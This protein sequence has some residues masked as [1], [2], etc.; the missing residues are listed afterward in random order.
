ML[1]FTMS[2]STAAMSVFG[3]S[4]DLLSGPVVVGGPSITADA[5]GVVRTPDATPG[6][7]LLTASAV[8]VSF[9]AE[10]VDD[11]DAVSL[12]STALDDA[13]GVL[14][15]ELLKKLLASSAVDDDA[16]FNGDGELTEAAAAVGLA[17]PELGLMVGIEEDEDDPRGGSRGPDR[18]TG[19]SPTEGWT[20][21]EEVLLGLSTADD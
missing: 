16:V 10:V 9:P 6:T 18:S 15:E 2:T 8:E 20:S 12:L 17:C 19:A 21:E 13:V 1:D 14:E 5:M 11:A 4:C 3:T 7:T